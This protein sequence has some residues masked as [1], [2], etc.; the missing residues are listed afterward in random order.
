MEWLGRRLSRALS[1]P[2][3]GLRLALGCALVA[4]GLSAGLGCA[5]RPPAPGPNPPRAKDTV[6]EKS[7][8]LRAAS[9]DL[10][11]EEEDQRFG[12]EEARHRREQGKQ[13]KPGQPAN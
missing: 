6:P 7:A 10:H 8:A 12:I 3:S 4:G 9:G 1:R 13:G 11:L 5:T 2:L